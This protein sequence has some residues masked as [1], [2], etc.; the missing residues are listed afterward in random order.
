VQSLYGCKTKYQGFLGERQSITNYN[1]LNK[2][3]YGLVQAA[4]AWGERF[5]S[6][7]FKHLKSEQWKSEICQFKT[8]LNS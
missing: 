3:I 8:K 1:I 4:G 2:S 5:A 6:V 7:L